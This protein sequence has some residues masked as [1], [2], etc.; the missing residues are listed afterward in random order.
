MQ[1]LIFCLNESEMAFERYY[2]NE[3]G[4]EMNMD[5]TYKYMAVISDSNDSIDN[6][7]FRLAPIVGK[8]YEDLINKLSI[9]IRDENVDSTYDSYVT[10]NSV[11][12]DTPEEAFELVLN[13]LF[14]DRKIFYR[15]ECF[16]V[17]FII[18]KD[19]IFEK[20]WVLNDVK[21]IP[22]IK[23]NFDYTLSDL[24]N[25]CTSSPKEITRS[26]LKQ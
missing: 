12:F 9:I 17:L 5:E 24:R 7:K 25:V 21:V 2:I 4:I 20:C 11:L 8:P 3:I 1:G 26:F 22:H 14:S 13:N 15:R 10:P 18:I 23:I 16:S 6:I 19:E